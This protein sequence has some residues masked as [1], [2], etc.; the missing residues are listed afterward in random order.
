MATPGLPPPGASSEHAR[1]KGHLGHLTP[2]EETAFAA[3]KKLSA[4]RGFYKPD[5]GIEPASHDD[6]TLV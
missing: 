5:S 2:Q 3:F 1:L 4:D 6:G